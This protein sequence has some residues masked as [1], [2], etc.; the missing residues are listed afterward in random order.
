MIEPEHTD[1]VHDVCSSARRNQSS[2]TSSRA[3]SMV[4]AAGHQNQ[5]GRRCFGEGVG[6][7]DQQDAGIRCDGPGFVPQRISASGSQRSGS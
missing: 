7:S 4:E 2:S 5:V 1:V 3:C 6:G